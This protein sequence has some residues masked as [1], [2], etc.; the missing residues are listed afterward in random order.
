MRGTFPPGLETVDEKRLEQVLTQTGLYEDA[1]KLAP[2]LIVRFKWRS[3][4][5][6]ERG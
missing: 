3:T 6:S 4:Y 5:F 2:C 1:Q